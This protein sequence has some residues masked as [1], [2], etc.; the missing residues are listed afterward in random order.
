MLH[1]PHLGSG[2]WESQEAQKQPGTH[3]GLVTI[4]SAALVAQ[5]DCQPEVGGPLAILSGGWGLSHKM[6][7]TVCTSMS[8]C[9]HEIY[10]VCFYERVCA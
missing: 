1:Q 7:F 8:A 2:L 9:V 4:F 10:C 5:Q 3:H 6:P